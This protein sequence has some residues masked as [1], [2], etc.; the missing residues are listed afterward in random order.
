MPLSPGEKRQACR[1][2]QGENEQDTDADCIGLRRL[3]TIRQMRE[4]K[5]RDYQKREDDEKNDCNDES[6]DASARIVFLYAIGLLHGFL[7]TR[8][9]ISSKVYTQLRFS[10]IFFSYFRAEEVLA[11]K[12]QLTASRREENT[13]DQDGD[14]PGSCD[15]A[16]TSRTFPRHGPAKRAH[17]LDVM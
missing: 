6:F 15:I 2:G 5:D 4:E 10:F 8:I 7:F 16:R 1:E 9:T 12:R 14:I 3:D 13:P 11:K 17:A